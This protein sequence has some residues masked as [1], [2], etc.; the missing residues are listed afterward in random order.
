MLCS[1]KLAAFILKIPLKLCTGVF[2]NFMVKEYM[3][4]MIHMLIRYHAAC[5]NALSINWARK[6]KILLSTANL[7]F[8]NW[9]FSL[10][11]KSWRLP[12]NSILNLSSSPSCTYIFFCNVNL[13]FTPNIYNYFQ[14]IC[15]EEV[16]S[17]YSRHSSVFFVV[18]LETITIKIYLR[19][20]NESRRFKDA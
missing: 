20:N 17:W 3:N 8:W 18:K 9:Y 14:T 2:N 6:G 1:F 11:I 4:V 10:T 15:L 7:N 16:T 12:G 19:G 5:L 13:A